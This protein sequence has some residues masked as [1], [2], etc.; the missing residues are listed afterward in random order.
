[1]LKRNNYTDIN[2]PTFIDR[3]LSEL[4]D[5]VW[6]ASLLAN[7]DFGKFD[8]NYNFRFVGKQTIGLYETQHSLQ[9]RPPTNPDNYPVVNYPEIAYSDVRLGFDAS[10]VFRFYVGVDNVFDKD[11][12]YGLDGTGDDAIYDNIGRFFY[13]GARVRF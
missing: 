11:P 7:F 3:Q 9:G 13:A 1:V 8:F 2:D 10:D 12:P 6:K 5:P 4:G